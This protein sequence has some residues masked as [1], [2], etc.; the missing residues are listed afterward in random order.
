MSNRRGTPEVYKWKNEKKINQ[1]I[2][3]FQ[4]EKMKTE[5]ILFSLFMHG[6]FELYLSVLWSQL[7]LG[8]QKKLVVLNTSCTF[9]SY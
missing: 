7:L 6:C 2:L 3:S 5:E 1:K 8:S 9:F 4:G